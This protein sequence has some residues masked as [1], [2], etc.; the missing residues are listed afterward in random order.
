MEPHR[1]SPAYGK[2][3]KFNTFCASVAGAI[4][5]FVTFAIFYDVIMRY[6]FNQ[7][8]IWITEVS[9]Y[10]LL[11]MTFLGT[12]FALQQGVH[13][14][15]TFLS[16]LFSQRVQRGVTFVT[17]CFALLF[18][19]ALL[20]QTGRMAWLALSR[21]WTSPSLLSV[22][23]IY[24]YACM[25]FGSFMLLLTFVFQ[26]ILTSGTEADSGEMEKEKE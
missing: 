12:A 25:V 9:T 24:V 5:I 16:D 17:S 6:L 22:P 4:L 1:F 10:L 18:C 21:G 13:I 14:R 20:W 15:V 3:K 8:S 23:L 2:I 7:P 11:Y 26:L 19:A